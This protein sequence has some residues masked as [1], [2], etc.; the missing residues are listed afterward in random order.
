L[1]FRNFEFSRSSAD[2]SAQR[3]RIKGEPLFNALAKFI[4]V[5]GI[6]LEVIQIHQTLA[7]TAPAKYVS[8]GINQPLHSDLP[9]Q[10]HEP[11]AS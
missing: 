1:S 4:G 9:A 10:P 6:G 2:G 5:R 7:L 11:L 3:F 8:P